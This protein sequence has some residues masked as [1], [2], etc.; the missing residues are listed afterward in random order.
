MIFIK[1][2]R[3]HVFFMFYFKMFYQICDQQHSR[4]SKHMFWSS[5]F[6]RISVIFFRNE[7]LQM[8]SHFPASWSK[9]LRIDFCTAIF[10]MYCHFYKRTL[11]ILSI[12]WRSFDNNFGLFENFEYTSLFLKY[13]P[14]WDERFLYRCLKQTTRGDFFDS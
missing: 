6:F 4:I 8:K 1:H 13:S 5:F 9:L 11:G 3:D 10:R 12:V 14:I 7:T 2:V